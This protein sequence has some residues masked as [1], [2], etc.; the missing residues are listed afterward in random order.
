MNEYKDIL[1]HE[2]IKEH[3]QKSIEMD[4]VSHAYLF[5]GDTGCGKKMM[6]KVFAKALLCEEAGVTPCG[7]CK[8]CLQ[9]DSNNHPDLKI[10]TSEKVIPGKEEIRQQ[11][12]NDAQIKPYSAS[13]KV[14]IVPKAHLLRVETQNVLLKTIEEPPSY[15]VIIFTT[16]NMDSIIPTILSRCVKIKFKPIAEDLIKKHLME[17]Y[18]MVDYAATVSA[19][20]SAGSIG[21]AIKYSTTGKF[22]DIKQTVVK[23]MKNI[24]TLELYEIME[25]VDE[26]IKDKDYVEDYIDMMLLWFRDVLMLKVTNDPNKVLY[27]EEYKYLSAQAKVR[28]YDG[29]EVII[30]A[31]EKTKIRLKANV[32]METAMELLV[33]TM[34]NPIV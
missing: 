32:H 22:D 13:R 29:L 2:E 24:D 5:T 8:S 23:M 34:K 12:V 25:V 21:R 15:A 28:G 10:V 7:K 19:A 14:Y 6:A 30:S 9:V 11:V 16:D 17:K 1:G 33:L 3:L 20:F 27:K 4:K 31:I 26:I 18:E